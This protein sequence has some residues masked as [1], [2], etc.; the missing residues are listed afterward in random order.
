MWLVTLVSLRIRSQSK[1]FP[2]SCWPGGGFRKERRIQT[3]QTDFHSE[4]MEVIKEPCAMSSSQRGVQH[5]KLNIKGVY[6]DDSVTE[7]IAKNTCSFRKQYSI[8][9]GDFT[10]LN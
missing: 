7:D 9:D 2:F 4:S 10:A 1:V 5:T 6:V 3:S 8:I